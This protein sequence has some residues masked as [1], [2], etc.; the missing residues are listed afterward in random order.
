M[1]RNRKSAKRPWWGAK[2]KAWIFCTI[3]GH[4][5]LSVENGKDACSMWA[6]SLARRDSQ[7]IRTIHDLNIWWREW[8][9]VSQWLPRGQILE[10][11]KDRRCARGISIFFPIDKGPERKWCR[12]YRNN[13]DQQPSVTAV[14]VQEQLN[15]FQ[16]ST[17]SKIHDVR[18]EIDSLERKV[19]ILEVARSE[20]W[21]LISQR[22]NSMLGRSVGTLSDRLTDLEQTVQSQRT[23]PA[24][25][26]IVPHKSLLMR[27]LL[28]NKHSH[29]KLRDWKTSGI[30]QSLDSVI[31]LTFSSGNRSTWIS[32]STD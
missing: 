9:L 23:T 20:S 26:A 29:M 8:V 10:T 6:V 32:N 30:E 11:S 5:P 28:L 18:Q 14:E 4:F 19:R 15:K 21:E 17:R 24:T 3:F 16:E 12:V 27:L 31:C 7:Q 2:I 25:E 22:L 1:S 13:E